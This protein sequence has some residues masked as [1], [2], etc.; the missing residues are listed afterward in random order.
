[1]QGFYDALND[2][3]I[4]P[5]RTGISYSFTADG[6]FEEAYYRAIANPQDPSCPSGIMQWQHGTWVKNADGSLSL[7][8]LA[9]DGRQLLSEPCNGKNAVYTR[10]N[11]S[12]SFKV[13]HAGQSHMSRTRVRSLTTRPQ[14]YEQLTDA[15]HNIPRLNLY[16]FDGSPMN[17]MYLAYSPPQMLPTT[18]LNPLA[19][20]TA[21]AT[22]KSSKSKRSLDAEVPLDWK[23]KLEPQGTQQM[24]QHINADRLWWFGLGLTGV[25]GLLYM[26]PRRMGISL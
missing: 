4:E 2:E 25:G 26:G 6:Y 9:V 3:F 5:S 16:K 19:T 23:L 12:E 17:P 20:A 1:L 18:T 8:P 15:Y 21:S 7:T 24:V 13:S 10:Y 22:G 14:S 11:Q